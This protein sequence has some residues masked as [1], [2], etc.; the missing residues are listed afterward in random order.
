MCGSSSS[1]EGELLVLRVT[2]TP[3]V[4]EVH[5]HKL[6]PQLA[7]E[8]QS[9]SPSRGKSCGVAWDGPKPFVHMAVAQKTGNYPKWVALVSG[10]MPKPA[11]CPSW[12]IL[13][14]THIQPLKLSQPPLP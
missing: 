7:R 10:K 2:G 9:T 13:S 6:R 8:A 3:N 12:L 4:Y 5:R 1:W 14:H 11:V